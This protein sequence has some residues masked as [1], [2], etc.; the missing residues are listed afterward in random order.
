LHDNLL[1][2]G[3]PLDLHFSIKHITLNFCLECIKM[4]EKNCYCGRMVFMA[5]YTFE[6]RKKSVH[7]ERNMNLFACF[8]V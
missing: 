7:V 6:E 8:G 3:A 4:R 1:F 5:S 2:L